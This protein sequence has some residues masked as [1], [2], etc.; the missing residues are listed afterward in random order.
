M[1]AT[2]YH[3]PRE[4]RA[5]VCVCARAHTHIYMQTTD[6]TQKQ[7]KKE[8]DVAHT[9]EEVISPLAEKC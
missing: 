2:E 8:R 4:V 3:W 1:E 5:R 6:A 9:A 7:C